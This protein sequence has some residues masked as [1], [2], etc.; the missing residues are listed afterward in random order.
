MRIADLEGTDSYKREREGSGEI[1][2]GHEHANG[3]GN[4]DGRGRACTSLEDDG[5]E[6]TRRAGRGCDRPRGRL[7]TAT[8]GH[9]HGDHRGAGSR[10]LALTLALVI[11]Y[12]VA[13]V[14]GGILS[15]SLA[16]LADAGHMLSD[17]AALGLAL[18]ALWIARRPRTPSHTYGF[19]RTGILAALANGVALV[20]ISI[21]IVREAVQRFA[22]PPEVDGSLMAAVATGGL[23]VN[24]AGLLILRGG[25]A[26][27]LN[28]RGAFLHVFADTLGSVQAIAAGALIWA[29]GWTW[30]D[31]LAS[32]LIAVLVVWSSWA[33]LKE[34]VNVLL[35]G[36]PG[37][38]D[39]RD[40]E[41]TILE[42]DGV[43]AIHDLHVWTIT[44]G[45]V[46]L[47]VHVVPDRDPHGDL[48]WRIRGEL[49]ARFDI[50]HTTVQIEPPR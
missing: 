40:I 5:S 30:V 45:F 20:V 42:I 28:V 48:L 23:L 6:S 8:A 27:S 10:R 3:H 4:E 46:A 19:H 26:E 44:S 25:R 2:I 17:A 29:F 12:M 49:R 36:V 32:L 15:N 1:T 24:L 13:E 33:L 21:F 7:V 43:A 18:F 41:R 39:T 11:V 16:L 31:P 47:S 22:D 38:L 37:H 14:V 35:E 34:A 50:E 9:D